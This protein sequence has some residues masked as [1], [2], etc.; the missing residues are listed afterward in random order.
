M[1]LHTSLQALSGPVILEKLANNACWQLAETAQFV[2][3]ALQA[4]KFILII[5]LA[6]AMHLH[7]VDT[8]AECVTQ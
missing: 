3:Q 7:M 6:F 4:N 2:I 5:A 1:D 8:C